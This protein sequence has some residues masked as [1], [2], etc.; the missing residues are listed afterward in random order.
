MQKMR[1]WVAS[2]DEVLSGIS[3]IRLIFTSEMFAGTA[4]LI[5]QRSAGPF[6]YFLSK[7]H[8]IIIE[9]QYKLII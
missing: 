6:R 5:E 1:L 9:R 2:I 4:I 3:E 7:M 8:G